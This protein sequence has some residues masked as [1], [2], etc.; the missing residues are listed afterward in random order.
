MVRNRGIGWDHLHV[1]VDDASRLA[2]TELLPDERKDSAIAFMTAKHSGVTGSF[3]HQSAR[4][5][6]RCMK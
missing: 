4:S 1:C 5:A 2:Y 6:G 3:F